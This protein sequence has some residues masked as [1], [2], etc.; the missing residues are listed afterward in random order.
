MYKTILEHKY[1]KKITGLYLICLHPDNPY[2]N[3]ER[4]EVPVLEKEMR[5]LLELRAH[6][7]KT[8]HIIGH[9]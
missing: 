8:G 2:K 6:E 9:H 4:I 1:G 5:D 3:Y 7:L